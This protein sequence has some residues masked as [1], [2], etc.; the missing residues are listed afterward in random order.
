MDSLIFIDLDMKPFFQKK[1]LL[2][3]L[4]KEISIPVSN[5]TSF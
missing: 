5:I 1:A 2:N 3:T 4:S